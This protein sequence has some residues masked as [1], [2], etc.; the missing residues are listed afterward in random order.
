METSLLQALHDDP[1][2]DA[3]WLVLADWL[4]EHGDPRAELVRL[5]QQLH[6]DLPTSRREKLEARARELL[7]QGVLPCVP[8]LTNSIGTS[9]VLIRP[10]VFWMGSPDEEAD[11]Y[12]DEHPRHRVEITRPFYLGAFQVTQAEYEAVCDQEPSYFRHGGHGS[13][14]VRRLDTSRFPVESVSW[15]DAT[16][17][18]ARLSDL[19][20]E[21]EAGRRYRLPTEAEWEYACRGGT[22]WRAPFHVGYSFS[23]RQGNFDGTMPYG[24]AKRGPNLKRPRKVGSY[25]PNAYGLYDMHG[26]VWEWCQDGFDRD[27]YSVSPERDPR[28]PEGR[29]TRVLRGGSFYYVASSCRAAIRLNRGPEAR[30]NLDG[31]RVA[32]TV[33]RG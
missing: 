26:N 25:P 24:T 18:C 12:G 8:T 30:S 17:F 7:Q 13:D 33:A 14:A 6:G 20:E 11:S 19:P 32:M 1:T 23:S 31:F 27:Y 5:S 4:E 3:T 10:G 28:G 16:Q 15:E 21:K 9:L 29:E 2:D 22:A